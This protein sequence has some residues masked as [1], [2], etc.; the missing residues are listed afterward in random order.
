MSAFIS[1][2]VR[3]LAV[4]YRAVIY[5]LPFKGYAHKPIFQNQADLVCSM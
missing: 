2:A 3:P 5:S 1:A 4:Y